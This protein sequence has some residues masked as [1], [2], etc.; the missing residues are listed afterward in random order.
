MGISA[1]VFWVFALGINSAQAGQK[2]SVIVLVYNYANVPAANLAAAEAWATRSYNA[3]GVEVSWVDCAVTAEDSARFRACE[4]ALDKHPF[5][6]SIIPDRMAARI[7]RPSKRSEDTLGMAVGLRAFVFYER[8]V[9][10]G[11]IRGLEDSVILGHTLA[12]EL[13]HL[14]LGEHSHSAI[15]VMRPL[16]QRQD[17]SLESGQF[18]FDPKQAS[19]LRALLSAGES[20]PSAG[21]EVAGGPPR[22]R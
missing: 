8:I 18:L 7:A 10:W 19:K 17:L 21:S 4:E 6:F 2:P 11:G 1:K 22:P 13:G 20:S 12:H 16:V 5:F 15:G 3:A 9:E 14:L